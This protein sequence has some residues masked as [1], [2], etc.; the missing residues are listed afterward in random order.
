AMGASSVA[1]AF[2]ALFFVQGLCQSTGWAPL[3]KN[4]GT[5]FSRRERGVVMGVWCSNYAVG[6]LIASI[7]AGK[8]GDWF[9]WRYAFFIPAFTLLVIWVF[10]L[11]LQRDRPED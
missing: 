9:G 3:S 6:G 8:V 7:Y 4:L 11:R 2:A 10:V 1:W 5:F